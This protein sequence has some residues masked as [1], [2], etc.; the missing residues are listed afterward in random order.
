MPYY[1]T[2]VASVLSQASDDGVA[3]ALAA[4][5]G[6]VGLVVMLVVALVSIAGMWKMFTKAGQ[7]GWASLVPLYNAYVLLTIAGRPGW[8]LIMLLIPLVNVVAAIVLF[9]DIAKSYGKGTGF[10]LGLI[11]L[12]PIFMLIL[13]FGDATYVGPAAEM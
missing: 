10:A 11:L 5:F 7:P 9:V 1:L 13:G 8:W 6:G 2:S 4:L 12:S 3:A